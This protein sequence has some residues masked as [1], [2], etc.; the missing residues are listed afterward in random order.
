MKMEQ[1]MNILQKLTDLPVTH[2]RFFEDFDK[3]YVNTFLIVD[4]KLTNNLL[5]LIQR[6]GEMLYFRDDT[7]KTYKYPIFD[8]KLTLHLFMPVVGYY[9]HHQGPIYVQKSPQRQWKRSFC[10]PLYSI[11]KLD[12][13]EMPRRQYPTIVSYLRDPHYISLDEVSI[14]DVA[15]NKHI[16]IQWNSPNTADILYDMQKIA[17][18]DKTTRRISNINSTF[19]QEIKDYLK[20]NRITKWNM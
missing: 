15:L 7:D 1:L 16:V 20:Y 19:E 11:R 3:R 12:G 13:T 4:H 9:N 6:D 14:G 18:I 5:F 8:E 2:E 10:Y 17:S